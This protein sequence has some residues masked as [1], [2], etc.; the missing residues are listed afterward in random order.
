MEFLGQK[1]ETFFKLLIH[2]AKLSLRKVISIYTPTSSLKCDNFLTLT[3]AGFYHSFKSFDPFFEMCLTSSYLTSLRGPCMT[4]EVILGGLKQPCISPFSVAFYTTKDGSNLCLSLCSLSRWV[5]GNDR[6]SQQ[7]SSFLVLFQTPVVTLS[8][9]FYFND[10]IQSTLL[11]IN[12]SLSRENQNP[13][14]L[15][16]K[17]PADIIHCLCF[18]LNHSMERW[19]YFTH[20]WV[21]LPLG[22]AL[23]EHN[24]LVSLHSET[25]KGFIKFFYHSPHTTDKIH[26]F[27]L[28]EAKHKNSKQVT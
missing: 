10:I 28:A 6:L 23:G 3:P 22:L 11:C 14:L 20:F 9:A 7:L 8:L 12:S 1:T 24:M 26:C 5:N 16:N 13:C 17:I 4:S 19:T 25:S 21:P 18:P 2:M 27:C 15:G